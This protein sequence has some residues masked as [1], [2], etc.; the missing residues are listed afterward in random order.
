MD[1][2]PQIPTVEELKAHATELK[3]KVPQTAQ[4]YFDH[5]TGKVAKTKVV[6]DLV[7]DVKE[8]PAKV[9]CEAGLSALAGAAVFAG[10]RFYDS[11]VAGK[12]DD[13]NKN[14]PVAV[15]VTVE[16][17]KENCWE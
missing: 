2:F 6:S 4:E 16:E 11:Y 12:K 7:T 13:G 17:S 14:E 8:N 3:G 1:K 15:P 5:V 9:G 10:L